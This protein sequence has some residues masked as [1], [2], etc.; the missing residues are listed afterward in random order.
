MTLLARANMVS[1][2]N[3][4]SA[5]R[6]IDFNVRGIHDI[7]ISK[8]TDFKEELNRN[9]SPRNRI[10][11]LT[12]LSDPGPLAIVGIMHQAASLTKVD[13]AKRLLPWLVAVA[14]FM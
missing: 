10:A 9:L 12:P 5:V 11:A 6:T 7:G 13:S 2:M 8:Q 3:I 4:L 1:H 14:L